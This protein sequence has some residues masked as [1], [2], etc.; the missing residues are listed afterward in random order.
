MI[1]PHEGPIDGGVILGLSAEYLD[2][3][4]REGVLG[5]NVPTVEPTIHSEWHRRRFEL[6]HRAMRIA[7]DARRDDDEHRMR[8]AQRLYLLS[9]MPV[10]GVHA[11]TM[12]DDLRITR[13][14]AVAFIADQVATGWLALTDSPHRVDPLGPA[15]LDVLFT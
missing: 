14:E 7:R 8:E 2:D 3:L 6:R 4:E 10:W 5:S 13:A 12:A 1:N 15:S 11:D 9:R